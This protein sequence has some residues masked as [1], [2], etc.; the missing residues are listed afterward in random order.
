MKE[1]LNKLGLNEKYFKIE[2]LKLTDPEYNSPM[3]F[4]PTRSIVANVN[5]VLIKCS[6]SINF[7]LIQDLKYATSFNV[8]LEVDN[9][10]KKEVINCYINSIQ[11]VRKIKLQK[12]NEKSILY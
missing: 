9:I 6:T 11:Y 2:I 5:G 7:E 12:L 3:N 4:I 1:I 8:D 10:L